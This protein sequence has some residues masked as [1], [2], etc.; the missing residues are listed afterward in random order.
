[1]S[2]KDV[3]SKHGEINPDDFELLSAKSQSEMIV[4]EHASTGTSCKFAPDNATQLLGLCFRDRQRDNLAVSL[5]QTISSQSGFV[6]LANG[7]CNLLCFWACWACWAPTAV[8][9]TSWCMYHMI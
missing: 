2:I 6:Y 4:Y 9:N 5:Q 7:D 3:G 1:M 8:T